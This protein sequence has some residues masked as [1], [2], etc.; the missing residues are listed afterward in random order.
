[1]LNFLFLQS[2]SE[3]CFLEFISLLYCL[4]KQFKT[5]GCIIVNKSYEERRKAPLF[6]DENGKGCKINAI[7]KQK[8]R[9]KKINKNKINTDLRSDRVKQQ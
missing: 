3:F 7:L 6:L 4:W 2:T 1:M 8:K 9:E 5:V